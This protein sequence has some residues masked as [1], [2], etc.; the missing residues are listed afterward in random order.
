MVVGIVIGSGVFF[1]AQEIVGITGGSLPMGIL[2]WIAGGLVM[3][4]CVLAFAQMAQKYEKVNGIID[5]AEAALGKSFAYYTGWFLSTIYYPALTM[6]LAWLSARFTLAFILSVSPDFPLVVPAAAGGI[7]LGPECMV[8]TLLY[9]VFSFAVNTLSPKLAGKIQVGATI[10]K[11]IPL[12]LMAV[13]GIAYGLLSGGLSNSVLPPSELSAAS[14][15]PFLTSV[16]ATAFAY[17]GWIIA[18]SINSELRDAKRNLPIALISGSVFIIAIYVL[19]FAGI[20]GAATSKEI[21]EHGTSIAFTHLFGNV[22]GNIL[23]LFV[24]ISCL[25]TLNGVMLGC[26]RGIFALAARN[27]GPCPDIFGELDKNT[28]MSA[29]SSVF[30]LVCCV[31]I[32]VYFYFSNLSKAWTGLLVFDPTELPILTTYAFYIPIFAM[33]MAKS[34]ELG[35]IRRFVIPS[36]AIFSSLFMIYATILAHGFGCVW[37]LIVF[38]AVMAVGAY[39]KKNRTNIL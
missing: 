29:N 24:A 1:K 34:K 17:D 13:V 39:F 2:A 31:L 23:N 6:S 9:L 3:L 27:E 35:I 28:N 16:C 26:S 33:W 8:L 19:Y 38:G 22:F 11:L 15:T 14:G 25:G 30:G 10:I 36:L 32:F 4:F 21:I 7:I 18:T 12:I 37:Y 5:Y 20:C